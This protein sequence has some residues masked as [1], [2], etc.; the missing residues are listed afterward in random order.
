M[1]TIASW[2]KEGN[3]VAS[4]VLARELERLFKRDGLVDADVPWHGHF[5]EEEELLYIGYTSDGE[6][7]P[8]TNL[9]PDSTEDTKSEFRDEFKVVYFRIRLYLARIDS[10][11]NNDASDEWIEVNTDRIVNM[12][13]LYMPLGKPYRDQLKACM[14]EMG[15]TDNECAT[16]APLLSYDA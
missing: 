6:M 7:V 8:F 14:I 12:K 4:L 10:M 3:K 5:N 13:E 16:L 11:L 2:S 1:Q 15:L 9:I